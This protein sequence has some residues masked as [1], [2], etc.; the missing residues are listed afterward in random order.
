MAVFPKFTFEVIYENS[1]FNLDETLSSK[2]HFMSICNDYEDGEWRRT[3]FLK[4]VMDNLIETALSYEE[5]QKMINSPFSALCHAIPRLRI[6]KKDKGK[7]G[8]IAEICLY[9]IMSKYFNALP[10][11]PKIFHKQSTQD[12]AKGADSVHIKLE[13]EKTFTLWFGEA[14]FYNS[15][16]SSRLDD[17]VQ[18]VLNAI[19]KEALRKENSIIMG[20]KD[21]DQLV[22]DK[23]M[24]NSIK[25]ML[26]PSTS[27]DRIKQILHIPILLL[28]QCDI[29]QKATELTDEVKNEIIEFH[30]H[31]AK[32]YFKKL[33]NT[34]K[35]KAIFNFDKINFHLILFPVHDK[36]DIVENFY[37]Q[38][39]PFT[40]L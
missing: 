38:I 6:V 35:E 39:Q 37:K 13:D 17:P 30:K 36:K 26:D 24:L 31:S 2:Q 9:G 3:E 18:S 1:L 20:L 7:G 16:D 33:N 4:F 40:T 25:S 27:I 34:Q 22:K 15:I 14:K 19:E 28:Y 10:V 23:N 8:E 32:L 5:R 12:N 11:V 21:L 29:T